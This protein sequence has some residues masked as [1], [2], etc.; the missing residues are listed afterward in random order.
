TKGFPELQKPGQGKWLQDDYVK[1][2]RFAQFKMESVEQ[3]VIGIITN[4]SFLDNP[5]FR[6]MRKSLY[7]T[8]DQMYFIDLHGNSKRKDKTPNGSKDE[9]V[10]DIEQ[11]VAISIFIKNN[12]HLDKKVFHSELWGTRIEKYNQCL[13]NDLFNS[14]FE[15]ILP[16]SPQYLFIPQ[17]TEIGKLYN[18]YINVKDILG[19]NGDPAPGIVTTQDEFAI[20]FSKEEQSKKVNQLIES[21][22]ENEARKLFRLC[23]QDQWN[24]DKAKKELI[25][26]AW[27]AKLRTIQYRPFDVRTTVFDKN[28]AVHLRKRVTSHF[29]KDNIG[30]ILTRGFEINSP[31]QHVFITKDIIQHH[32]MSI[33]E[34]NF[35]FPLYLYQKPTG[36]FANSTDP[37]FVSKTENFTRDFRAFINT[38]YNKT[39]T[40]EQ[41]LGYIYA[42]LHSPAYRS[43]YAEFLKIDFHASHLPIIPKLSKN[44]RSLVS[45]SC[46]CTC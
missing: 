6:G 40:P 12:G 7:D 35:L 33:K 44:F 5:T 8:F 45:H 31:F 26:G 11:G 13:S 9:N 37:N 15:E 14:S 46:K 29:F 27:K 42:I 28:V 24:Y 3:G 19:N 10:F 2:I 4:H 25:T 16:I 36:L 18:S 20:S 1:F 43:K 34:V 32:S 22:N 30:L 39:Y 21:A 41:I 17:N 23:T 38:K